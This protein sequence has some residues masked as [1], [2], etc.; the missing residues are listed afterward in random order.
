MTPP[1]PAS[2]TAPRKFLLVDQSL[3][4]YHGHHLEYSRTVAQAAVDCGWH[5]T[6]A[7]HRRFPRSFRSKDF[8]FLRVFRTSFYGGAQ[9]SWR[10]RLGLWL[11]DHPLAWLA[12][13]GSAV[14][15]YL[16][17]TLLILARES[18]VARAAIA[19]GREEW[20]NLAK[21][22]TWLGQRLKPLGSIPF[23][24]LIGAVLTAPF[25]LGRRLLRTGAHASGGRG[26]FR[27]DLLRAIKRSRLGTGD[28]LFIHSLNLSELEQVL[29]LLTVGQKQNMPR[30]HIVLRR[31]VYETHGLEPEG[32]GLQ[33]C[34]TR[35]SETGIYPRNALFYTDS[36]RLTEDH[37]RCSSIRF[38]TLPIPLR[39]KMI[40]RYSAGVRSSDDTLNVVYLGDARP[41]KGYQL[42]PALVG[43]LWPSHIATDRARFTLQSNFNLPG[44]E[45]GIA[46]ARGQ[47]RQYPAHQVRLLDQLLS[48]DEYYQHLGEADVVLIPYLSSAYSS[49]TSGILAEAIAA[50]KPV[51]VPNDTWMSDQIDETRGR[52]F[53]TPSELVR[54]V[55]EIL[56]D[57]D[58]FSQSTRAYASGWREMHSADALVATLFREHDAAERVAAPALGLDVEDPASILF[59]MNA[60]AFV[61]RTG[62]FMVAKGQLDYFKRCGYRVYAVLTV[63]DLM[64]APY[65]KVKWTQRVLAAVAEFEFAGAWVLHIHHRP[66]NLA[67]NLRVIASKLK[68]RTSIA[69]EIQMNRSFSIPKD[70]KRFVRATE[71][72]AVFINY[73]ATQELVRRIGVD[74]STPI[75]CEMVDIQSHQHAIHNAGEL[76][77]REFQREVKLL[78]RCDSVI[79]ISPVEM[80]SIRPELEHASIHYAP[81]QP[82]VKP[83]SYATLAGIRELS[84]LLVASGSDLDIVNY[85]QPRAGEASQV[86][87]LRE[88]LYLDLLF[89]STSHVP[90]VQSFEWFYREIFLPHLA[91]QGVTLLVAGTIYWDLIEKFQHPNLFFGGLLD[92]LDLVYAA[93]PL[94]VLPICAGAGTNIKTLEALAMCKPV[95][96]TQMAFRGIGT[97]ARDYATFD[98][99]EAYAEEIIH[100]LAHPE[101]RLKLIDKGLDVLDPPARA[102]EFDSAMGAAFRHAIGERARQSTRKHIVVPEPRLVEW[103]SG[104][105]TF[106]RLMRDYIEIGSFE[107]QEVAPIISALHSNESRYCFEQLYQS[108]MLDQTAPVL[109]IN[110]VRE[111]LERRKK[112]LPSFEGF[113]DELMEHLDDPNSVRRVFR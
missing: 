2:D 31:E 55:Q 46:Q 95:V 113:L 16:R 63:T 65:D 45:P 86:E 23:A 82:D 37:N 18:A 38:V 98:D 27:D 43:A 108:F 4:G 33:T 42:L 76:S 56:D 30:F 61:Y 101:A 111:P 100:L 25:R 32:L 15:R 73:V 35:F 12:S 67:N 102:K 34:L 58:T 3:K 109:S 72:D 110:H 99:P 81:K 69:L 26:F 97:E 93:C 112:P 17:A 64:A 40:E 60:D 50:G 71:L 92:S 70:L 91:D 19:L 94:V 74:S 8:R 68:A 80:E 51:V 79:A 7:T 44:G 87:R 52:S 105:R 1:S 5:V 21:Q 84:E 20:D 53:D 6:V 77:H 103:S 107:T 62:S 39:H 47:L 66:S 11:K 41:E 9:D 106:N 104:V 13:A 78:D 89:V 57:F 83:V 22:L 90:N 10:G 85:D 48:D 75:I 96:S 49:R 59:F 36:E 24:R 88:T 14:S 29:N 54:A 28:A